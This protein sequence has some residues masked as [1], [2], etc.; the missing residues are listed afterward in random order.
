MRKGE[1]RKDPIAERLPTHPTPKALGIDRARKK[2]SARN[3]PGALNI[4]SDYLTTHL[5]RYP[6]TSHQPDAKVH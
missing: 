5:L 4:Q 2:A 3:I 6:R 1:A